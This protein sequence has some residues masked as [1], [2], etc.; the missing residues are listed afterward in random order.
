MET[1]QSNSIV[2]I[3]AILAPTVLALASIIT[4]IYQANKNQKLE[5]HK[6]EY[7]DK[8]SALTSILETLENAR[9][10]FH[11]AKVWFDM[12]GV[13]G[14]RKNIASNDMKSPVNQTMLHALTVIPTEVRKAIGKNLLFFS[15]EVTTAI[16]N[17]K[18]EILD[19]I[20]DMPFDNLEQL[21]AALTEITAN[22]DS[23]IKSIVN[24]AKESMNFK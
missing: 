11:S 12:M 23:K 9:S 14:V 3:I 17:Y 5:K 18:K 20:P 13:E 24:A 22:Y 15:T 16:N 4:N 10:S 1:E 7:T 19:I 2:Q 6:L 21:E 8:K